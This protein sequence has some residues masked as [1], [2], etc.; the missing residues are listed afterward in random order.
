MAEN[1]LEGL[2]LVASAVESGKLIGHGVDN[3]DVMKESS[4]AGHTRYYGTYMTY[5]IR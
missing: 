2:D 1:T 4:T 3:I 5:L